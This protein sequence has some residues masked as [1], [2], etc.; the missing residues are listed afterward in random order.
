LPNRHLFFNWSFG[1]LGFSLLPVAGLVVPVYRVA[2]ISQVSAWLTFVGRQGGGTVQAQAT[3]IGL[4]P[5]MQQ[6]VT[7]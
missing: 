6:Q 2:H 3:D 1:T 7:S 4:T 5:A